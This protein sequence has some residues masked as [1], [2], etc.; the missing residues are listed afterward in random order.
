MLTYTI[1]NDG[2]YSTDAY[3]YKY[4]TSATS[5]SQGNENACGGFPNVVSVTSYTA[6]TKQLF[7]NGR[8]LSSVIIS[9]S[10]N[11][12][13]FYKYKDFEGNC[14]GGYYSTNSFLIK[15]STVQE[16][17]G[18]RTE[19]S[20]TVDG[21]NPPPGGGSKTILKSALFK[22][23]NIWTGPTYVP[24]ISTTKVKSRTFTTST[25]SIPIKSSFIKVE[26]SL[27]LVTFQTTQ[28]T[29]YIGREPIT[30]TVLS[31]IEKETTL[32][33]SYGGT[34]NVGYP[35]SPSVV[36]NYVNTVVFITN[37][38]ILWYKYD[39]DDSSASFLQK[40]KSTR[41]I[42]EQVTIKYKKPKKQILPIGYSDC[43]QTGFTETEKK[44][45]SKFTN[46]VELTDKNTDIKLNSNKSNNFPLETTI[47]QGTVLTTSKSPNTFLT[48]SSYEFKNVTQ[49]LEKVTNYKTLLQKI[50]ANSLQFD[51]TYKQVDTIQDI[52]YFIT[53]TFGKCVSSNTTFYNEINYISLIKEDWSISDNLNKQSE[54]IF[55][56][57]YSH[58]QA[59]INNLSIVEQIKFKDGKTYQNIA[60]NEYISLY[61]NVPLA[62]KNFG[63]SF[64]FINK[65]ST[66]SAYSPIKDTNINLDLRSVIVSSSKESVSSN[67]EKYT[68]VET[69]IHEFE[70]NGN[71]PNTYLNCTEVGH[72]TNNLLIDP[73]NYCKFFNILSQDFIIN[74][75]NCAS[76]CD[77]GQNK[78]T[79]IIYPGNYLAINNN[80]IKT[81][82]ISNVII[83]SQDSFS[84]YYL[85]WNDKI[86]N[87]KNGNLISIN[88]I[89]Y[90][91]S[92]FL[93]EINSMTKV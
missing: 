92:N 14:I 79:R 40:F 88:S 69:T 93:P 2:T 36:L 38:N 86:I 78:I 77:D 21:V 30:E 17:N 54:F 76:F 15:G 29:N 84:Y 48:K 51:R 12:P 32:G 24:I 45:I 11:N 19:Y 53:S 61:L 83:T 33:F 3:E 80:G 82:S 42:G 59:G 72:S 73:N 37:N 66:Q 81:T 9:Y 27:S 28:I 74:A 13:T 52:K 64:T 50:N 4:T 39:D 43:N 71:T 46:I 1:T 63:K 16:S 23:D 22:W 41:G 7:H 47:V 87:T 25:T 34:D 56:R 10:D 26:D 6:S 85:P 65:S 55:N 62:F 68:K 5:S 90:N 35:Y 18:K 67:K 49:E 58:G 57:G 89:S 20:E 91:I 60:G 31:Q 70:P 75:S 8:A 44:T